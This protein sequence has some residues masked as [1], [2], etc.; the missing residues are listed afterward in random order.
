VLEVASQDKSTFLSLF[1]KYLMRGQ[2]EAAWFSR[3][4]IFSKSLNEIFF[5]EITSAKSRLQYLYFFSGK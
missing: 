1:K 3:P 2:A 4:I 5:D